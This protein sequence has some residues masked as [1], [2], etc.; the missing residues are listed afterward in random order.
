MPGYSLLQVVTQYKE[1][2]FTIIGHT[3]AVS[4]HIPTKETPI[5]VLPDVL[6]HIT[7]VK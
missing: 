3:S 6:Q 7:T 5:G 4:H 1:L 2:F